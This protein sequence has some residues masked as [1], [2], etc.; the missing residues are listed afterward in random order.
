MHSVFWPSK[1]EILR[2]LET[3]REREGGGGGEFDTILSIGFCILHS[4]DSEQ[5][6]KS[7]RNSHLGPACTELLKCDRPGVTIPKDTGFFDICTSNCGWGGVCHGLMVRFRREQRPHGWWLQ[8]AEWSPTDQLI[9]Q[10]TYN[11]GRFSIVYIR[12]I[13]E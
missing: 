9:N 1:I 11:R 12:W 10:S 3:K 8:P 13:I 6:G 4:A 2:C 7:L 5:L